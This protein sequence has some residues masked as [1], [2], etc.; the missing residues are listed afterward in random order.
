MS[1][2][3]LVASSA[4]RASSIPSGEQYCSVL[5]P[6]CVRMNLGTYNAANSVIN[7]NK[8]TVD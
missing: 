8:T 4:V 1:P 6:V 5:T 7:I 3:C 2:H